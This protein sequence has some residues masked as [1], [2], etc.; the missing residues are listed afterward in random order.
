MAK[1]KHKNPCNEANG[2]KRPK[3]KKDSK[4]KRDAESHH[5]SN[6][7]SDLPDAEASNDPDAQ[8]DSNTHNGSSWPHPAKD[9]EQANESDDAYGAREPLTF[10][11]VWLMF[12]ETDKKWQETDRKWQETD[13][14]IREAN[15]QR[16]DWD[17]MIREMK[18]N[19]DRTSRVVSGL[20]ANIGESTEDFFYN[21]LNNLTEIDGF[22][23]QKVSRRLE[24]CA[25][26]LQGEFDAVLFCENDILIIVEVKH[27]LHPN[28]V[29]RFHENNIPVFRQLFTEYAGK[30]ILGAVAGLAIASGAREKALEMGL[31]LLTQ[32]NQQIRLLNPKGFEPKR[33]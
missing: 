17:K 27:K 32:T 5:E 28:D 14:R 2:Y 1:K 13:K 10:E 29:T 25:K 26:G 9:P 24:A 20:G 31:L 11:K 30:T 7:Q 15:K 19:L 4:S 12:Q 23:I 18:E 16:P 3:A 8:K 21:A 22:K 33:F 6:Q